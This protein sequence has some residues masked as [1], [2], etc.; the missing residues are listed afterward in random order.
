MASITI[1]DLTELDYNDIGDDISD[2]IFLA[3]DTSTTPATTRK[4]T[5]Q[6]LDSVIERSTSI[7]VTNA[8]KFTLY[9]VAGTTIDSD[10]IIPAGFIAE[11]YQPI[12]SPGV[13][14]TVSPGSEW[15][16]N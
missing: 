6:T 16:I 5:L 8:S 1:Q 14:V 3:V 4:I 10:Y 15:I 7:A 11:T 13:N 2:I 9:P 12:L